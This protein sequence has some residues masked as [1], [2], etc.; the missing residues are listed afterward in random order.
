MDDLWA[1]VHGDSV[2]RRGGE[3]VQPRASMRHDGASNSS[4][5]IGRMRTILPS[6]TSTWTGPPVLLLVSL[7][8]RVMRAVAPLLV[9]PVVAP[10]IAV[11]YTHLRAHETD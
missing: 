5:S 8:M 3:K 2:V 4:R 6:L 11:S 9:F 7:S 1:T 10:G